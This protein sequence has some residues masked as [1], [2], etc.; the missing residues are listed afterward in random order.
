MD[1][2]AKSVT[3][4]ANLELVKVTYHGAN[5]N[6]YPWSVKIQG[7]VHQKQSASS[8]MTTIMTAIDGIYHLNDVEI[9]EIT[10]LVTDLM[11]G[12]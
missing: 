5:G 3:F 1:L 4:R 2:I 12:F 10:K 9:E 6:P 7:I 8:I 11:T